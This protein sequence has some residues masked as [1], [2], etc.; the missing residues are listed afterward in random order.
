MKKFYPERS[1]LQ[2][3]R[4][5]TLLELLVV[6]GIIVLFT[7]LS[8]TTIFSLRKQRQ[9]K[10]VADQI[11]TR[12]IEAHSYAVTPIDRDRTASSHPLQ[13]IQVEISG[14]PAV[15]EIKEINTGGEDILPSL[16]KETLPSGVTFNPTT[17]NFRFNAAN[18]GIGQIGSWGTLLR[19]ADGEGN[20]YFTIAGNGKTY[21][22]TVNQLT[23]NVE[24]K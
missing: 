9:V 24:I 1:R 17:V 22:M 16:L 3:R 11:K 8:L 4:A 12:I 19:N 18:N 2:A 6:I 21:T 23:G 20:G 5:F 10:V 7:T 14:T 13:M 15:L